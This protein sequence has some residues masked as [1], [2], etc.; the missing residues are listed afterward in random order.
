[1]NDTI[2]TLNNTQKMVVGIGDMKYSSANSNPILITHALGSCVGVAAFDPVAKAGALLHFMLPDSTTNIEKSEENPYMFANTGILKM[3]H[4]LNQMGCKKN[5][6]I[7]KV[8]GGAN[9]MDPRG[10]FDIGKRNALALK[11]ILWKHNIL[12]QGKDIGGNI[13]RNMT[14]NL[15]INRVTIRY[16]GEQDENII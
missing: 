4:H 14:L 6:L 10:V 5:R 7:V 15:D 12:I 13:G 8:A 3:F 16:N 1:M 9:I 11:K 2:Q